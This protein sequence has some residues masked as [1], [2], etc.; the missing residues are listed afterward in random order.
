MK[1]EQIRDRKSY[2]IGKH[3][4]YS[5]RVCDLKIVKTFMKYVKIIQT[6]RKKTIK[7]FGINILKIKKNLTYNIQGIN[8]K[9]I[10][11]DEKHEIIHD[12]LK[13]PLIN[14][15]VSGNNNIIRL[16]LS[17]Y[18]GNFDA[19]VHLF[20]TGNNNNYTLEKNIGGVWNCT[21][22]GDNNNFLVGENTACGEFNVTLHGNTFIIGKDCMISALEE[23]W[24]DGHSVIDETTKEVLN[25]PKDPILIGNHCWIGRRVTFT[26]SAQIPDNC[27]VGIGSLVTKKFYEPN[28]VI[29]G[30][31]AKVVKRGINWHGEMPTKY[32]EEFQ[33]QNYS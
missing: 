24:T 31:P 9:I 28:C 32:Y 15:S 22:L 5:E 2:F 33:R 7:I 8:N 14:I 4:I 29:A 17:F 13:L 27:I 1:K 18:H 3:I 25:L 20:I 11:Y 21:M 6:G 12:N 30:N 19:A 10:F 23:L 16:P 26:K